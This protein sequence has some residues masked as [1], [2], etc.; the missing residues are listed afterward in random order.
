MKKKDNIFIAGHNGLVGNSIYELFK[1][2]GYKKLTI[3]SKKKLDLKKFE[4]VKKFF[5]K[6]KKLTIWLWQLQGQ[7]AL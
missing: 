7:E 3:I 1:Q 2:K 6:K 5:K 4:K